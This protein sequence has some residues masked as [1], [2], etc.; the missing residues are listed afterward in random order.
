MA[1]VLDSV[2][3]DIPRAKITDPG[4]QSTKSF[5]AS[6]IRAA[7]NPF[8]AQLASK[9][10]NF[11]VGHSYTDAAQ[12]YCASCGYFEAVRC[13]QSDYLTINLGLQVS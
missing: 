8:R 9:V 2:E 3:K 4:W 5:S 13:I 10:R 7:A 1:L 11:S 12:I 6:P